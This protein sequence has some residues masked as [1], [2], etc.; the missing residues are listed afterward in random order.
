M[1]VPFIPK[2]QFDQLI[3]PLGP[4]WGSQ[5]ATKI[6][7]YGAPAA[8]QP[9]EAIQVSW[10]NRKIGAVT[11]VGVKAQHD[12][13][14]LYFHLDW[15]DDSKN[16]DHGDNTT[17]PDAAAI[18]LPLTGNTPL[19]TM[20]SPENG[21]NA[22]YWRADAP[23]SGRNVVSGGL[24]TSETLDLGLDLVRCKSVW[25]EGHWQVVIARALRVASEQS[26]VQLEAGAKTQFGVAIWEGS[27]GE[28]GGIKSFSGSWIEL[29][30]A[31]RG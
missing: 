5:P 22:W 12:G 11:E 29:N 17:F 27:S 7:M 1:Q 6:A 31:A 24:G 23:D 20:G 4:Y 16:T 10:A 28:R 19:I 9:T 15:A 8:M 18:S 21:M 25:S 2:A 14:Y 30:L 13:D 26:V 3:D